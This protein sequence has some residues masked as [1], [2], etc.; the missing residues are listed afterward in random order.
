MT[1][2]FDWNF[3]K[4][5]IADAQTGKNDNT[6]RLIERLVD[7]WQPLPL[8][9]GNSVYLYADDYYRHTHGAPLHERAAGQYYLDD[10][11][12][13]S[14]RT[15]QYEAYPMVKR[16]DGYHV[17]LDDNPIKRTRTQCQ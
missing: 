4:A 5:A 17:T 6:I 2:Y 9:Q 14:E 16:D 13:P 3:E 15:L 10:D 8:S 7:A 11:R 1:E 12:Y